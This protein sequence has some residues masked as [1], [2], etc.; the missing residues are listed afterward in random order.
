MNQ[1]LSVWSLPVA[2]K[3]ATVLLSWTSSEDIPSELNAGLSIKVRTHLHPNTPRSPAPTP[4][5]FVVRPNG[6]RVHVR[7]GVGTIVDAPL[8][9]TVGES[10][11]TAPLVRLNVSAS[12]EPDSR[13]LLF[14]RVR[15][16][17]RRS[18]SAAAAPG[19]D[20]GSSTGAPA[21]RGVSRRHRRHSIDISI[22]W[23]VRP[24]LT[25]PARTVEYRSL[26]GDVGQSTHSS[27]AIKWSG[28]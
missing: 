26:S 8:L 24:I 7:L 21:D 20:R 23:Y 2:V 3:P 15:R 1:T 17:G 18:R 10:R 5:M 6:T 9:G 14:G 12:R 11:R 13:V 25:G 28:G 4:N 22:S 27:G 19:A 16:T